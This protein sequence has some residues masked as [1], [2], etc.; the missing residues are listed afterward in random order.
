MGKPTHGLSRSPEYRAW[1]DM[2]S[3]CE[4]PKVNNYYRY[5]GR[6]ITVCKRWRES[7]INFLFDMK[8]KPPGKKISIERKDNEGNYEPGNCKWATPFEQAQNRRRN[9]RY[10]LTKEQV[11]EIRQLAKTSTQKEIAM[12]F[13]ITQPFVSRVPIRKETYKCHRVIN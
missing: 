11:A 2:I 8:V 7:F 4:N 5:G 9:P 1:A 12:R 10:K 6:G 13:N 3:R